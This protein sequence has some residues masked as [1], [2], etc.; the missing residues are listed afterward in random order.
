MERLE[1]Q[2][3][4]YDRKSLWNQRMYRRIKATEMVAA[5]L[6][7]FIVGIDKIPHNAWIAGGLGVLITALEGFLQ[8]YN[9]QQTW[10]NYRATCEGLKHEKYLFLAGASPYGTAANPRAMLAERVESL[11]SQE[12]V[13][14]VSVQQQPVNASKSDGAG[15]AE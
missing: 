13:K 10:T 12:N 1:D 15:K 4:Y 11:L 9:F 5:A 14:W 2:V 8:L 3:A 7:P 6:I